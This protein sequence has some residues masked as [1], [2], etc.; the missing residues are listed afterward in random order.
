[1]RQAEPDANHPFILYS[2]SKLLIYMDFSKKSEQSIR[3]LQLLFDHVVEI[4][5]G[6]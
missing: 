1:M 5:L 3:P 2:H 4:I 6:R